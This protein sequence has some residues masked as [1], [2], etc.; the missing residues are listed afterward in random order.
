MVV[1]LLYVDDIILTVSNYDEVDRLQDELSLLF[2][3]KKLGELGTFFG[4]QI[5]N[6][7]KGL[8]VLQINYAKK[9]V[10]NFGMTDGK[11]SY[12]P[13]DVNPRHSQD[14]GSCLL[15]PRPYRAR[16]GSLIYLTITRPSIAYAVGVA[17]RYM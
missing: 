2:E 9:L 3:L 8:F 5:E 12:T 16:V 13:L 7:D 1:V 15:D 17:S 4:L 11:K 14:E 10:E 6:F